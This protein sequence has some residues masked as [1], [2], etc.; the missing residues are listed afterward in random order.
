M[1]T[2]QI[3][4]ISII[5]NEILP[6]EVYNLFTPSIFQISFAT[7]LYTSMTNSLRVINIF[8]SIKKC[9]KKK[10]RFFYQ[11]STSEMFKSYTKNTYRKS[12]FKP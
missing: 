6:D 8:E 12:N 1:V 7:P 5:I 10:M 2:S 3:Q 4:Q 9:V 11:T